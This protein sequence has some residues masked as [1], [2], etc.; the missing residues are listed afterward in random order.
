VDRLRLG[1]AGFGK[2][3]RQYYC[4]ALRDLRGVDQVLVADP[5]EAS[6]IA[7]RR[8]LPGASV[9][10]DPAELLAHQPHGLIV[11]TP[12][13]SHLSLWRAAMQAGVP[14][15]MEKPFVLRGQLAEA[16]GTPRERDLLMIDF[17]RRFWQPYRRM[18][19]LAR[20]G[21]IGEIV[22]ADLSLQV[23]VTPWC[24]VTSHRLEPDE[25]GVLFDLGSQ[26]MDLAGWL[27]GRRPLAVRAAVESRR[28]T[29]DDVHIELA[30]PGGAVARCHVGY[31]AS[32]GE[33]V[34]L[35]GRDGRLRM[36]DPNKAVHLERRRR[37]W[38]AAA[39]VALLAWRGVLRSRSM[40]RRSIAL[41]IGAFVEGIRRSTPFSPGFAEAA[42]SSRLLDAAARSAELGTTVELPLERESVGHG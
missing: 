28:W 26:M 20:S 29:G 36:A 30:F 1:I 10:A 17:N 24:T 39:D 16:M 21:A 7:A 14:V 35:E 25:G 40:S 8:A 42:A 6:R 41:A 5:L 11:A 23:D 12:P 32:T 4:P 15:L 38:A 34:C 33:R 3:A 2:L 13:S 18:A 27:L 19:A 31:G 37:P 9:F 22:D